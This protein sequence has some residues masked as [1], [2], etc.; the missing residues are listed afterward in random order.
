MKRGIMNIWLALAVSVTMAF[1]GCDEEPEV[2]TPVFPEKIT[3]TVE[4]GE[5]YEFTITA[6][7]PWTLTMPDEAVTFFK[8]IDGEIECP[9]LNGDAGTHTITIGVSDMQE[10]NIVRVCTISM[11]MGNQTQVIAEITRGSKERALTMYVAECYTDE[12]TGDIMFST[13][14]DNNYIYSST[15]A[16][17]LDWVWSNEQWMQRVVIDANF[18]WYLSPD[19]PAWL[20]INI[21]NG[22]AGRTELF[23][24]VNLEQLPLEDVTCDIEFGT[25]S[26]DNSTEG[27]FEAIGSYS[28]TMEGCKDVC[29]TNLPESVNFNADGDY[30]QPSSDSYVASVNGR[31]SSPRGAELLLLTKNADGTYSTEAD[32]MRIKI[33]EDFPKEA[34]ENGV[35]ERRFSFDVAKHTN[36]EPR[37]GAIAA[38]PKPV[39][40]SN[41][42]NPEEYIVCHVFQDGWVEVIEIEPIYPNDESTLAAYNS[43]FEKLTQGLW[44]WMGSWKNIPYGYKLTYNSN[45]SGDDLIFTQP[46]A[47]YKIYGFNGDGQNPYDRETCWLT[48]EPSEEYKELENGYII[49]SRLNETID[50]VTYTNPLAGYNGENEATIIFYDENGEMFALIYFILDPNYFTPIDR[51]TGTISF[52]DDSYAELGAT[53]EVVADG[54]EEYSK[55]WASALQYRLTLNSSCTEVVLFVPDFKYAFPY[56]DWILSS[57]SSGRLTVTVD[58]ASLP[59]VEEGV[60]KHS[61]HITLHNGSYGVI[62]N[63][64]VVYD[65]Q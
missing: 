44:P 36:V 4:A 18:D 54:D 3:A 53:L 64:I 55:E 31:I 28:T 41:N 65:L 60:T 27:K 2:G 22:T 5:R 51:P 13:D 15:P 23:L 62:A 7:M 50:G 17:R 45:D 9:D 63:L 37:E 21:N 29:T 34:G 40:E 20:N 30:Y 46:F 47:D 12:E 52:T 39:A 57:G 32:W 38:L 56:A 6:N 19:A 14:A 8:F 10:F 58:T 26:F 59:A 11:T 16:E 33:E 25:I 61:N 35:W 24:R 1:V 42:Y 49:R 48:I 43:K